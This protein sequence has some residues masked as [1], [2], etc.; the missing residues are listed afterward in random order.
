MKVRTRRR[1][2]NG[3]WRGAF[4]G[5]PPVVREVVR[6][7]SKA[8]GQRRIGNRTT[9]GHGVEYG[10]GI[11]PP[12]DAQQFVVK[13]QKVRNALLLAF[14]A[15][16]ACTYGGSARISGSGGKRLPASDSLLVIVLS[17]FSLE[18]RI[19]LC[20]IHQSA[21]RHGPA[22]HCRGLSVSGLC[23]FVLLRLIGGRTSIIL[24]ARSGAWQ[25]G[26]GAIDTYITASAPFSARRTPGLP[27]PRAWSSIHWQR[28]SS[29]WCCSM[30][31]TR[32]T[33]I[34][35]ARSI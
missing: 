34:R 3:R 1:G 9:H 10:G 6:A 24:T 33:S 16:S 29:P 27:P 15:R 26:Y 5:R 17:W 31:P 22:V 4:S 14:I 30:R 18:D 23:A 20:D 8:G 13:P 21:P 12:A 19:L 2:R 32:S 7:E 35:V 25:M 28:T 11:L